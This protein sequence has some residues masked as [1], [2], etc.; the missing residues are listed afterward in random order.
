MIEVLL[1]TYNGEAF[2]AGQIDSVLGQEGVELRILV[3]DDGSSDNTQLVLEKYARDNLGKIGLLHS[4]GRL[5]GL[6]SFS[7]LLN[8]ARAPYMA[9]C[10]Q[11]DVWVVSKLGRLLLRMQSLEARLGH[12]TPILV[13]SDLAV[14]DRDL[15]PIHPSFWTYSG[16]DP[17][18]NSLGQILIK[19]PVTGCALLANRALVE[20]VRPIPDGAVM[21]D[22]WLALVAAAFGRIEAVKEPLVFYRQ[23]G[24]NV[25]GARAYGWRDIFNR[26]WSSCGRMDISRLRLQAGALYARFAGQLG[27]EQIALI[28]G[29][30]KLPE[31][32][33][34]GRRVFLIRHS[35]LMPGLVRNL[36]LFLC[37][38]LR[39]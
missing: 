25:V 14:V 6:G 22:H 24:N 30:A 34:W 21:H 39:R 3:R 11:D 35:I 20:K 19:N 18:R 28:G 32:G 5:G 2:L 23:H 27:P 29:F 17:T 1:A 12:D 38:R 7:W 15:R 9:F 8:Q 37:V 26:L 36:A 10:D 13:H 31:Y 16:I 33:W 4:S